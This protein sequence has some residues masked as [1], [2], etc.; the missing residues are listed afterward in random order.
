LILEQGKLLWAAT[1][2]PTFVPTFFAAFLVKFEVPG[3]GNQTRG[4]MPVPLRYAL[5]EN[6]LKNHPSQKA[7]G[8]RVLTWMSGKFLC[9]FG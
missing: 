4:S 9:T 6:G 8:A 5:P 2:V 7:P 1:L 3:Y